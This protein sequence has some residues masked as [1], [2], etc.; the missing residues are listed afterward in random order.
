MVHFENGKYSE[1]HLA[2]QLLIPI[3]KVLI[4]LLREILLIEK[5]KVL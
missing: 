1:H 5:D 4:Q 3:L 2:M